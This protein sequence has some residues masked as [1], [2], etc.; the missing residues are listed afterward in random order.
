M[1]FLLTSAVLIAVLVGGM[2][3][4]QRKAPPP[5]DLGRPTESIDEDSRRDATDDGVVRATIGTLAIRV[6]TESGD[7]PERAEVG[8]EAL[9]D[10][11]WAPVDAGGARTFT[12][13][14]VGMVYA[15]AR[16]PGYRPVRQRRE[17]P[18]GVADEA[19]LTLTRPTD[20]EPPGR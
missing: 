9:H 11:R 14:P 2:L 5:P 3:L 12:N 8:F 15:L 18:P 16:A 10:V 13:V 7:V 17:L 4:L 20:P 1:R 6:R 19:V